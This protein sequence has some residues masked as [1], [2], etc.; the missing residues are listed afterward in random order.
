MER[1]S[2]GQDAEFGGFPRC[3]EEPEH[4]VIAISGAEGEELMEHGFEGVTGMHVG[5]ADLLGS[6]RIRLQTGG[7]NEVGKTLKEVHGLLWD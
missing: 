1:R 4:L 6:L 3:G 7:E 2:A 5:E